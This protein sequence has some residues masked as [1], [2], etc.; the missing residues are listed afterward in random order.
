[1]K[2]R[3]NIIINFIRRFNINLRVLSAFMFI[4][5]LATN[6][7]ADFRKTGTAGY[8]FLKIPSTARHAAMGESC[9]SLIDHIGILPLFQN[10]AALGF[11]TSSSVGITY[12]P[13]IADINHQ[14]AGFCYVGKSIGN[15]GVGLNYL[16]YGNIPHTEQASGLG[17]YRELGTYSAQSVAIGLTYARKLTD[18]FAYGLRLNWVEET[19]YHYSSSNV[20]MDV[21]VVYFT[22]FRSLRIGGFINNFGVDARFIGDTFKMPTELR[23]SLAYDLLENPNHF[24]TITS[25]LSHPSDNIEHIHVGAEYRFMQSVYLRAG[26][27]YPYDE[28]DASF[29]AGFYWKGNIF[30]VAALPFGRFP[31]VF[32]FS[33]QKE[34]GR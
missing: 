4:L 26:Y 28:D 7:S 33:F 6:L 19:I 16:D 32:R 8:S 22:G 20:L 24:L 17:Q 15:F 10:P 12:S 18:K 25:E 9:G 11:Q 29:G 30:D 23:L 21:G 34:L 14:L 5:S 2:R 13:W 27:K 31:T 1:M 3:Y